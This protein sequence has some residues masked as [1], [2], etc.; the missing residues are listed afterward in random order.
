MSSGS[1]DTLYLVLYL[2]RGR[3]SVLVLAAEE[4]EMA[5]RRKSHR[6]Q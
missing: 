3:S 5:R 2:G 6:G 1:G 4:R